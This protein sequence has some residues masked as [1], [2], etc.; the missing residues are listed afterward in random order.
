[1]VPQRRK[2]SEDGLGRWEIVRSRPANLVL[3]QFGGATLRPQ[4]TC[5]FMS[6]SS[7]SQCRDDPTGQKRCTASE[8]VY[9]EI[10][11][12]DCSYY[13]QH[14]IIYSKAVI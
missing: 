13:A 1:M 10:V 8:Q 7:M 9:R 5:E 4:A 6:C 12:T 14:Q 3:L 11:I 2:G